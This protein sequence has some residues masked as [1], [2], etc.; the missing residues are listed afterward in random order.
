MPVHPRPEGV[1]QDRTTVTILDRT[2]ES[3]GH[4]RRKRNQD[5]LAALAPH[6]QDPVAVFL[7]KVV[8]V[9]AAGLEDPQSEQAEHRDKRE[10][11][12][13]TGPPGGGDRRLELQM[14][15]PEGG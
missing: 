14:A 7:A 4:R 8:D 11:V 13:V 15:Q 1:A 6:P 10:V 12:L 9:R 3:A 2:V 5:D